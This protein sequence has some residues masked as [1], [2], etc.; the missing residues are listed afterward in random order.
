MERENSPRPAIDTFRFYY[1]QLDAGET[2][3]VHESDIEP[4]DDVVDSESLPEDDGGDVLDRAVVI[5]LNGGLGTSMGMTRAKS[6]LKV[7]EGLTFLDVIARQV[8]ALRERSGARLPLV[9]MNSFYTQTDS[10]AALAGYPQ[11]SADV[12][13]DFLQHKEP[14]IRVDDLEPVSWPADPSKE[15]CPPGHGDI[16]TALLTSGMLDTLLE[17]GYFYAFIANSDNLGAV[18]DPKILAWFARE[19]ASFV[20]EVTD[21]TAADRKGGHV[22]RRADGGLLLRET[23]QTRPEDMDAFTDIRRHRYFNCN[24]LWVDLRA[25]REELSKRS[26]VL[27]LPLIVNRKT[28]DP[29]DK[30]ST[31]VYQLETAMGA[32]I[33]VF[34]DARALRVPRRRFTPVKTTSDLM[35]V[36]SDAF[37]LTG[38]AMIEPA[39][40]G[41]GHAPLVSLDEHFKLLPDFED[42]VPE[43]P[44]LV[45][46]ESLSVNGDVE[47]GRDVTVRGDVKIA[48]EG[49]GRLRIEDGSVL[50]G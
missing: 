41:L 23:A 37:V 33:G 44:S 24:N 30:S 8:L 17:R 35:I 10:L 29:G 45:A 12:P 18:L 38:D 15:W 31:P 22:A 20:S 25:L 1:E 4:L 47:F 11:L 32:A 43:P 3:M 39:P 26:G 28:V 21:R 46:C 6:L 48:H 16:Y 36:R 9:L 49:Q 5:R 14:K 19:K 2:G 7:K 13:P 40:H 34:E 27:G 42:R 50:S